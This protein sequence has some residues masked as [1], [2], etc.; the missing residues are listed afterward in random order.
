MEEMLIG[1]YIRQKRLDKGWT[2]EEL[3]DSICSVPT[4][5]RIETC[6]RT[7]SSGVL[8]ALLEKLG[9]PTGPFV[10]LL[11]KDDLAI[12]KLKKDIRCDKLRLRRAAE[13]DKAGLREQI[14]T[15]LKELEELGGEDNRFV[16][17]FL[18]ST[19]AGI[20]GP[21]GP[22][23]PEKR[24][25]ML[26]EAICLTVPRFTVKHIPDF[27]Y[28]VQEVIVINQIAWTYAMLGDRKTAIS[29]YKRLLKYIEKY[30]KNLNKYPRQFG[31]LAHNCAIELGLEKRY[32]E[33]AALAEKGQKVCVEEGDYQF[34]P[35]FLAIQA[36]SHFFLGNLEKS[37]NLYYQ[38]YY[39]YEVLGDT[40]NLAIMKQEMKEYFGL[41]L[42]H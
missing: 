19:E 20:G 9:L 41:E 5:S 30:N 38:A 27:Q 8:K 11:G 14:L 18:L 21:E 39:I 10:A 15:K 28:S 40:D 36:E 7:P 17:Q 13:P 2:Q 34:L 35:G 3:C 25:E 33:A 16:R 29:I 22:Y 12:E 1:P 42:P 32:K 23:P 6:D 24:L 26:L 31:M 4:L 37:K